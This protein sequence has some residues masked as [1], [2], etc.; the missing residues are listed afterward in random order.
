MS[1]GRASALC[2]SKSWLGKTTDPLWATKAASKCLAGIKPQGSAVEEHKEEWAA[3]GGQPRGS[4]G[5]CGRAR[6]ETEQRKALT[7]AGLQG[8][9]LLLACI[10]TSSAVLSNR[11]PMS[12]GTLLGISTSFQGLAF[13]AS[14]CIIQQYLPAVSPGGQAQG[15]KFLWLFSPTYLNIRDLT[16]WAKRP[17]L[18]GVDMVT[19]LCPA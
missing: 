11:A 14:T 13:A 16:S 8:S 10:G 19:W 7:R 9:C 6:M 15:W 3:K 18:C 4:T 2:S 1:R 17:E 12:T 5:S